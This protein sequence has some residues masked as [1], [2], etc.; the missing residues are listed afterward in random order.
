MD[1]QD[2]ATGRPDETR[3]LPA[4]FRHRQRRGAHQPTQIQT[5]NFCSRR[6][7]A[8]R[9]RRVP[10]RTWRVRQRTRSTSALRYRPVPL[11]SGADER[12]GQFGSAGTYPRVEAIT[13]KGVVP[14]VGV[15]YD[16]FGDTKT[17]IKA[18][19]GA[20]ANSPGDAFSDFYNKN[21]ITTTTYRWR[22]VNGNGDYDPGET[23]LDT[24]CTACDFI[25]I[26]GGAANN[27]LNPDLKDPK[28]YEATVTLDRELRP[29]LAARVSYLRAPADLRERQRAASVWPRRHSRVRIR[30]RRATGTPDDRPV[31][32]WLRPR[33]PGVCR[34]PSDAAE[35]P[36]H[37][38]EY[39]RSV[40]HGGRSRLGML[41][42]AASKND[43]PIAWHH[44]TPNDEHSTGHHGTGA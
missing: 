30:P 39:D 36:R 35:R 12:A 1:A 29:N 13:W 25:S 24:T 41:A 4:D 44:Q 28:T 8:E 38:P 37:L 31:N 19:Y 2:Y 32:V 43:R 9:R 34:Q 20:F 27:L 18:S 22:D 33:C 14:R 16:L 21:T 10:R 26:T 5:T 23:N 7:P 42:C 15:A 6:K 17:V 3:K 11:G 40:A